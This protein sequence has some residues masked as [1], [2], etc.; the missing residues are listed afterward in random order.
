MLVPQELSPKKL[1]ELMIDISARECQSERD[2]MFIDDAMIYTVGRRYTGIA[3]T[4]T[5]CEGHRTL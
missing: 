1:L 3:N 5:L 2:V 4:A